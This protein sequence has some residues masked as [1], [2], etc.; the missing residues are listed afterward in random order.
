MPPPSC[1]K[2]MH[3]SPSKAA[4]GF[5]S[6]AE[7]C[8]VPELSFASYSSDHGLCIALKLQLKSTGVARC[9]HM[10]AVHNSNSRLH[11]SI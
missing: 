10:H 9:F 2:Q 8:S 3:L 7:R 5:C 11:Q 6:E 4:S 1:C